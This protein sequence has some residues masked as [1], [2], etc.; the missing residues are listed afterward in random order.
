MTQVYVVPCLTPAA[1]DDRLRKRMRHESRVWVKVGAGFLALAPF[2]LAVDAI[3]S[4]VWAQVATGSLLAVAGIVTQA[5]R[6]PVVAKATQAL[7]GVCLAFV[8]IWIAPAGWL[9]T[10]PS[11]ASVTLELNVVDDYRVPVRLSDG[12]LLLLDRVRER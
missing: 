5:R 4:S 3:L 7:A 9:P 12:S 8:I 10:H 11:E 1:E 6:Y 2:A